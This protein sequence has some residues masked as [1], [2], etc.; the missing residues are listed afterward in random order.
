MSIFFL[1]VNERKPSTWN[2][3]ENMFELNIYENIEG[4]CVYVGANKGRTF[5]YRQIEG[6]IRFSTIHE[7]RTESKDREKKMSMQWVWEIDI[8]KN[9]K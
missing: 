3:V 7:L 9:D 2:L 4:V 6:K 5:L 1:R 8:E